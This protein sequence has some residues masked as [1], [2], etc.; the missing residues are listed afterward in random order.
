MIRFKDF[1]A[2]ILSSGWFTRE[3]EPLDAVLRDLNEW[4]EGENV[5]VLNIETVVLP[6]LYSEEG[7]TDVDVQTS[8]DYPSSWNQF[9]RVWYRA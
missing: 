8:G 6:N 4:V 1:E 5:E 3:L 9:F 2:K 7:T